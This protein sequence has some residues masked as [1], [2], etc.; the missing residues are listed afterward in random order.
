[1][2]AGSDL[3]ALL[4]EL[5]ACR[6]CAAELPLGPRP[7]VQLDA[8]ARLLIASQAP[9]RLAHLSGV[10]F[11]D[12]SG[13]RLRDWLGIGKAVF[14]DPSL[15]AI[16]PTGFCYPGTGRGGDLAP[17]PACAPRWHRRILA[18]LPE[19]RLTLAI[20][21]YAIRHHLGAAARPSLTQTVRDFR[22]YLPALL[23]LPHPSPRNRPW[24]AKNPWFEAELLPVLREEV[25]RLIGSN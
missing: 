4:P 14:Y 25:G 2:V 8:R 5:R 11:D 15:I 6:L 10:S 20:G 16:L 9:G 1:M 24:L 3:A 23:P 18:A 7:I 19:L 12:P 22:R 17:L 13:D 21:G